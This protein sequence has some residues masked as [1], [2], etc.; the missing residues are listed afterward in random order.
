MAATQFVVRNGAGAVNRGVTGGN[1]LALPI[2]ASAGADISL[3]LTQAQ[4][5]SYGRVGNALEITLTDGQIIVVDNFFGAGGQPQADLYLSTNGLLTQVELAPGQG[6]LYYSTY[7]PEDSYGKFTVSDDLYF[8]PGQDTIVAAP[9]G[10]ADDDVG[11]LGV[12]PLLGGLGLWPLLGAAALVP[13]VLGGSEE[14]PDPDGG[15]GGGGGGGDGDGDLDLDIL[16]GTI[17]AG[18]TINAV[19]RL[20]GTDI[21]GTGTV[22]G[23]VTVT[24]GDAVVVTTVGEDGGWIVHFEPEQIPE[25]TYDQPV[26]AVITRGD[27]S[28]TV[29]DAI[30]VD[31]E[32]SVTFDEDGVGGDGTVNAVENAGVVT[33][34]GT[35]DAGS[36][37]V[38]TVNE[39]TYTAVVT[40]TTWVVELVGST[41]SPGEYVQGVSVVAT[42]DVGNTATV[43][44]D[45]V[46]DTVTTVT[47]DSQDFG[48]DFVVNFTERNGGITLTGTA[49]AGA[50]VIVAIEGVS[51]TVTATV[52]GTWTASWTVT[53]LPTGNIEI[54]TGVTVTSTDLA[55]NTATATGTVEMDTF[56]NLLTL[57]SVPVAGDDII[58]RVEWSADIALTGM[59]EAGSSVTV[60]VQGVTRTA[61]VTA[62]GEWSVTFEGGSLPVGEYNTNIVVNATDAA[63]N[64]A[65]ITHGVR[66][67]TVVGDV[68]LSADPIEIDDIV[69]AVEREDGVLIYGTAT[70]GFDVTVTLGGAIHVV[71][72]D[73]DGNWSSLF[74]KAEIPGGTYD[75]P[76]TASI[77]DTAG[78]FKS[79]S[80]TVHIDTELTVTINGNVEGD[81]IINALE[82]SDGVVFSGATEPAATVVVGFGAAS[83]TVTANA[84]GVW[85]AGFAAADIPAGESSQTVTARATD[86]AGNVANASH[87]FAVDT[88]VNPLTLRTVEGDNL[89]NRAEAADGIELTGLVERG[90]TSVM[91]EYEGQ[92]YRANISTA[93]GWRVVIPAAAV[94]GGEYTAEV[95]I[96]ATDRVGNVR[97][98]EGSFAVDTTPP[99]A[100]VIESYRVTGTGEVREFTT[101]LT[102]DDITI[103]SLNGNGPP[104][105]VSPTPTVDPLYN[106]T[107]FR[108]GTPISAGTHLVMTASDAAGNAT[109]TLFVVDETGTNVVNVDR[110]NLDAFDIE[111][112]D[113]QFAEDS[114]LTLSAS[115]L[116][117]LSRHSNLLTI[118]G[119]DDDTVNIAGALATGETSEI[120]GRTYEHYTLGDNGGMLIIDDEINVVT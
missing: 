104:V 77:T 52:T 2:G 50:T 120:G 22:G 64:T 62:S 36:T 56:V 12:A 97:T 111:G 44:G 28:L 86:R 99:V 88:I 7:V 27:D 24:I 10:A 74:L 32:L 100:P 65:S 118:H 76:I 114:S 109:S 4:I 39:V 43:T 92:S 108:F 54:T 105:D 16:T 5:V 41:L 81:N 87:G 20:D 31:T 38:V 21:T 19:E 112:I 116:E 26:V 1:G 46:V 49:E 35:T 57:T 93:G 25:G 110:T 23:T 79:V 96:T 103:F 63:G 71:V 18:D 33:L 67:D 60:T 75:A 94:V 15:G 17:N 48:G 14:R 91:V 117:S 66:V 113:L 85:T 89:V 80:D 83:R 11:M 58:N 72:A 47:L 102:D 106:E 115:Q 8:Y 98:I 69:N 55:G 90:A 42:D 9:V 107:S 29:D 61:S 84:A 53:D 6:G 82:A 30:H 95:Q 78:N 68:T 40:G 70:A 34:T 3:N 45:F 101:S 73:A 37:V 13:A 119:G 59:V 51:R